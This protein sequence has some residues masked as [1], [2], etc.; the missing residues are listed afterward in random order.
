[1]TEN[2]TTKKSTKAVAIV[3]LSIV[4]A[5]SLFVLISSLAKVDLNPKFVSQPDEI[6]VYKANSAVPSGQITKDDDLHEEFLGYYNNMFSSS[7]LSAL[8]GGRL[9]GY[10][11]S[12]N[13]ISTSQKIY[14]QFENPYVK[15]KYDSEI[16]LTYKNG[17]EYKSKY[18][19]TKTVTFKELYFEVDET[20]GLSEF[21]I[22]VIDYNS[23]LSGDKTHYVEV[24]LRANTYDLSQNLKH[25]HN[26]LVG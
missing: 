10:E 14:N 18:D 20:N 13:Q 8:F 17:R 7:F 21:K 25:F 23:S 4:F 22:Y 12:S 6:Y 16:A 11:L 9:S 15:F 5:I 2:K 26:S 24:T 19:S 3:I 1:M